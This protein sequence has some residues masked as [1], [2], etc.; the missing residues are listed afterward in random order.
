MF[1]VGPLL[2]DPPGA[3][4]K[5][6]VDPQE[7]A[8]AQRLSEGPHPL[9]AERRSTRWTATHDASRGSSGPAPSCWQ[10]ATSSPARTACPSPRCRATSAGWA[11]TG[12]A[13]ARGPAARAHHFVPDLD[14]LLDRGRAAAG[15]RQPTRSTTRPSPTRSASDWRG[16]RRG[17]ARRPQGRA[18]A[19]GRGPA[20]TTGG[21]SGRV[22][23]SSSATTPAAT[24]DFTL[25]PESLVTAVV[26][27]RTDRATGV[28]VR[29]MQ[30]G[31]RARR[32]GRPAWSSSPADALRTPQLL[33]A[34]GIRPRGLGRY[35]NDQPQI[36]F[37]V[38]L[39][40]VDARTLPRTPMRRQPGD[41]RPERR[42]LGA[43]HRRRALPRPGH[44][45]RRLAGPARRRRRAD[46]RL[47]RRARLVLREGPAGVRPGRVRR[48]T[49]LDAYGMP[50]HADPLPTHRRA[51]TRRSR[52]RARPS[53]ARRRG[54]R[55]PAR[56]RPPL[57]FPPGASLHYQ[58]TVRMGE[59]RRRHLGVRARPRGVGRS[60]ACTSPATASSRPPPP[61]TPPSPPSPSPSRGARAHRRQAR[62]PRG[63]EQ[64]A[65]P[66]H[67]PGPRLPQRRRGRPG[68]RVPVPAAQPEL[69]RALRPAC[70][71]ASTSPSTV[72]RFPITSRCGPLQGRTF[73]LDELRASDRRALA[74]RR[75][76]DD[77]RPEARRADRR[78]ARRRR[79][80]STAP[81]LLPAGGRRGRRSPTQ[82]TVRA[83]CRRRP[84]GGLRY[85]VSTYSYSGDIYTLDDPRGRAGRHRRPRRHRHR[86]PRRGQRPQLPRPRPGLGRQWH[87]LVER[88]RAHPHQLRLLGR[89]HA[90]ARPR[91]D[92]RRGRRRSSSWTSGSPTGSA[93]PRSDRSSA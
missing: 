69:P 79:R 75:D 63:T 44:A 17:P 41:H 73:T 68:H 66:K 38:R 35:L 33:W 23:T 83:S 8:R 88:L 9:G 12:P 21:S 11:R 1:E 89:H 52:R 50:G 22:R 4:V 15:R 46:A 57:T 6:I 82:R 93:S 3:H 85:G 36:V 26:R 80:A 16:A 90:V 10:R 34:S 60:P 64:H 91:P 72:S 67:H 86:D 2:A 70:S 65:R 31:A 20:P 37:A 56:R 40:D 49:G 53:S 18:D 92:R 48:P 77:H 47:D 24:R 84:D 5:N 76:G 45:A 58:G 81:A 30:T 25:D 14:E 39:R 78:R 62:P 42:E 7:R 19:A 74:A 61:A 71:T 87:G 55:R 51:T 28:R 54:A 13:R 59:R 43:V 29:D 32:D 27:R